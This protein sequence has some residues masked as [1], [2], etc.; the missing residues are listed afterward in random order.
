MFDFDSASKDSQVER[1][2]GHLVVGG[3]HT[4]NPP[5]YESFWEQEKNLPQHDLNLRIYTIQL[6]VTSLLTLPS[7]AFPEGRTGRYVKFSNQIKALGW[8]NVINEV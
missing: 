8:N 5:T 2:N 7:P 6:T 1:I 3:P 4:G